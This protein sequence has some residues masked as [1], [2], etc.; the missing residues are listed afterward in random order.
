MVL[1]ETKR[2]EM[3]LQST[4]LAWELVLCETKRNICTSQKLHVVSYMMYECMEIKVCAVSGNLETITK[5][6]TRSR[7]SWA[8]CMPL[9]ADKIAGFALEE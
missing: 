2:N 6:T 5:H 4:N 1:C 3:I 8:F 7:S 9:V